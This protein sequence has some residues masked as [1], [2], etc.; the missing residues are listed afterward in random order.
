MTETESPPAD[1]HERFMTIV[2]IMIAVVAVIGAIV[3]WRASVA[4]DASG[5]ADYGGLRAAINAEE[6]RALNASTAYTHYGAYVTYLRYNNLGDLIV[7][8]MEQTTEEEAVRLNRQ[9]ADAHDIALANERLFPQRFLN[10]NGSYSVQRELGELWA[11]AARDRDLNPEPQFAEADRLRT[12]S[13][14]LLAVVGVLGLALVFY[15]LI[16]AAAGRWKMLLFASGTL[17]A[18]SA[19][20]A[21]LVLELAG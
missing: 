14:A 4:D 11:D 17:L 16:E 2:A 7:T 9:R 18:A 15:T 3:A 12:K 10:R 20:I 8:D 19:T 21:A 5:D 1:Q 6:T 13:N